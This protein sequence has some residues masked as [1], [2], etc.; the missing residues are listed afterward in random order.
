[1]TAKEC[2]DWMKKQYIEG[3]D[4]V[5]YYDKWVLAV[6]DLNV[7][8][9]RYHGRPIGNSPEMM[10]LDNCLNKDLHESV[11]RHVMM[12]RASALSRDN[13]RLFH[14]PRRSRLPMRTNLVPR[15]W[16]GPSIEAYHPR[17]RQGGCC[18]EADPQAE[19]Y[20]CARPCPA[21]L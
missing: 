8:Y 1:M 6:L 11:A 21:A 18:Y 9:K 2:V 13:P 20:L 15:E 14:L 5:L 17:H 12:S 19:G 7:K 3:S 4:T 10:P 16:C